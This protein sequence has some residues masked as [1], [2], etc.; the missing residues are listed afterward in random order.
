MGG[1]DSDIRY[2]T[3]ICVY[4]LQGQIS[5]VSYKPHYRDITAE[6]EGAEN[7]CENF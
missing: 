3:H 6:V 7:S 1:S 5:A 2:P 4:Y